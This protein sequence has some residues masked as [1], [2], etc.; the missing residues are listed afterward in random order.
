MK[1][2][3]EARLFVFRDECRPGRAFLHNLSNFED[4]ICFGA[5]PFYIA[6]TVSRPWCLAVIDCSTVLQE[7]LFVM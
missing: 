4:F 1:I 5:L 6:M 3:F 7:Y 2:V